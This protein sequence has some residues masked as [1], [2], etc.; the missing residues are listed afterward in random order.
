MAGSRRDESTGKV[1]LE[2][3][4]RVRGLYDE[5]RVFDSLWLGGKRTVKVPNIDIHS[6]I[7]I[8]IADMY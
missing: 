7:Y 8:Q 4:R 5:Q 6:E 2:R 1:N 3:M